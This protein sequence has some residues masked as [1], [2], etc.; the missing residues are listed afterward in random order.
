MCVCW[1]LVCTVAG[2]CWRAAPRSSCLAPT[3]HRHPRLRTP[4]PP[5]HVPAPPLMD[6]LLDRV[7]K[8]RDGYSGYSGSYSGSYP[9][10]NWSWSGGWSGWNSTFSGAWSGDGEPAAPTTDPV[11]RN[12]NEFCPSW[13]S[14][15]CLLPFA[16]IAPAHTSPSAP[17]KFGG[18]GHGVG[19][20]EG[21]ERESAR[22]RAVPNNRVSAEWSVSAEWVTAIQ[23]CGS[24]HPFALLLP[25]RETWRK[26]I[27]TCSPGNAALVHVDSN[28]LAATVKNKRPQ[29][30]NGF[31]T[32]ILF[33]WQAASGECLDNVGYGWPYCPFVVQG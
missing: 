22:A 3:Q 28:Y 20:G 4:P 14:T 30:I 31:S 29:K 10:G 8:S 1:L 32:S 23:F 26:L 33:F 2:G 16:C 7:T 21:G 13:A 19:G 11:C 9:S 6:G 27:F 12:L 15:L 25:R 17:P 18:R 5:P 24:L